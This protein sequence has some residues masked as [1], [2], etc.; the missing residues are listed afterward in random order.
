[1]KVTC[2]SVFALTVL[3]VGGAFA[4]LL[5]ETAP[6]YRPFNIAL[7]LNDPKA[8]TELRIAK[9]QEKGIAACLE[10][11]RVKFRGDGD[12]INKMTGPDKDAKIRALT[13]RRSDEVLQSL[14]R[15]LSP[16]Q[17]KRL[18]QILLQQWRVNLFD[19]PEIRQALALSDAQAARIHSTHEQ[20]QLEIMKQLKEGRITPDDATRQ[21]NA[22]AKNVHP[23]V[24]GTL[25]EEQRQALDDLIRAPYRFER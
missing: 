17:L 24:R 22:L 1:M 16:S 4:N 21:T 15:V 23:R 2:T 20:I 12:T 18:K 6:P 5:T 8:K 13:K 9:T 10:E 19:H 14:G 3:L 7:L 11:W 25:S